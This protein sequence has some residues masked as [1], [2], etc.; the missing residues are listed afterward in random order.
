MVIK[1]D[2]KGIIDDATLAKMVR[3]D[4]VTGVTDALAKLFGQQAKDKI[5]QEA[6]ETWERSFNRGISFSESG[7]IYERFMFKLLPQ[8]GTYRNLVQALADW[9]ISENTIDVNEFKNW[10]HSIS[11]IFSTRNLSDGGQTLMS[12]ELLSIAVQITEEGIKRAL[13][14]G[15]LGCMDRFIGALGDVNLQIASVDDLDKPLRFK[16]EILSDE[17]VRALFTGKNIFCE[18]RTLYEFI[19]ELFRND[20]GRR[21]HELLGKDVLEAIHDGLADVERT[22]AERDKAI[23][24]GKWDK[25]GIFVDVD[26]TLI[27][28]DGKLNQV[29]HDKLKIA[30]ECGFSVTL[31]S[32]GNKSEQEERLKKLGATLKCLEDD[33]V[34]RKE[35]LFGILEFLIDDTSPYSQ[36][37]RAKHYERPEAAFASPDCEIAAKVR[38]RIE[39]RKNARTNPLARDGVTSDSTKFTA[40]PV[41]TVAKPAEIVVPRNKTVKG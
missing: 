11:H 41:P 22:L 27:G 7:L 9:I 12:Q 24:L 36:G 14:F 28:L 18:A 30:E 37:L 3:E 1:M 26:G 23:E 35:A 5:M 17:R 16:P 32:G 6:S 39:A 8:L 13:K 19:I 10:S 29:L 25:R 15:E 21:L 38:E 34:E 20:E 33:G 31:I 2:D 4:E 40:R